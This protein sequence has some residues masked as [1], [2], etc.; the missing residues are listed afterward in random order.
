MGHPT[1]IALRLDARHFAALHGRRL[2]ISDS[3]SIA[4]QTA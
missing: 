4:A 3:G 2:A 1:P